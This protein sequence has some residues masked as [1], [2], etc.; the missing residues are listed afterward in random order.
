MSETIQT[1]IDWHTQAFPDATLDGQIIK[2]EEEY[3]EYTNTTPGTQDELDELAD[4]II[5]CC[6][7]MRFDMKLGFA[8]LVH[9]IYNLGVTTHSPESLWCAVE[10]KMEENRKRVWKKTNEGSYHHV[11]Q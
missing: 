9:A 7:I 3:K 8:N 1:I 10:H 2:M 5:V 6:G 11:N 4:M